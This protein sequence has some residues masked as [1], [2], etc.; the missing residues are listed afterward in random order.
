M[1]ESKDFKGD[2]PCILI[3]KKGSG[4]LECWKVV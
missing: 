2:K 1:K 4:A 3:N